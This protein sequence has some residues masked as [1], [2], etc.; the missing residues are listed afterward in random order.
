M[1]EKGELK[2]DPSNHIFEVLGNN[3]YT[4][5]DLI[6]ELIDNAVAA[7]LENRQ[8]RIVIEV[9]ISEENPESSFFEIRDNASGIE[10]ENLA[11]AISPAGQ[12]EDV[13]HPL[14]EHGLGM[15]QAIASAGEL[16][17]LKTKPTNEN[18]ATVISE[19]SYG[20][21]DYETENVDWNHGTHIKVGNLREILK[22]SDR[23]YGQR[24]LHYLGAR[25]R[26]ML[27]PP[28]GELDIQ[29]EWR[30]LD[31]DDHMRKYTAEP[32]YPIYFHPNERINKPIVEKKKFYGPEGDGWVIE[33]TF[34]Y[35]PSSDAEYE[36]LG[37]E[38]PS[39]YE[40]YSVALSKQGLDLMMHDRVIQFHQ[41]DD[42]GLVKASHNQYNRI[43]GEIDMLE[44]FH[45]AITKNKIPESEQFNSM[46][47]QVKGFLDDE[48]LLNSV[49]VPGDIPENCLRD[50]LAKLLRKAP[51]NKK[52]I[53]TEYTVGKLRGFVDVYA[54]GEAWEIKVDQGNGID[55]YQL[56]GYMDMADIQ[57]GKFVSDG[58]SGGA[59]QAIKH[60][61]EKH[62]KE[63]E[64]VKLKNL[65]INGAMSD[66]EIEK[67][68]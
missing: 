48:N 18:S 52:N 35:A 24:I 68:V 50:R 8:L 49:T 4:D 1:N 3:D 36:K 54:D 46:I 16:E 14:N 66:E 47:S 57:V 38:S 6:S 39:R 33:L 28:N 61:N 59:R 60:I 63:I 41:L 51:Y 64:A 10:F 31:D 7:K 13:D 32:I 45:T 21:I 42:I 30:N 26:R 15:K 65:A 23:V 40:P 9:G 56:F 53:D 29:I 43:R 22:S 62:G 17:F 44:G 67:Y 58:I 55:V 12:P 37:I 11:R 20:E 27:G 2:V 19:F 25:Y 5:I 34:G